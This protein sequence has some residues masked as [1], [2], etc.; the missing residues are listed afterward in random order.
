MNL[1]IKNVNIIKDPLSIWYIL[2]GNKINPIFAKPVEQVSK[3]PGIASKNLFISGFF[4][5]SSSFPSSFLSSSSSS[6]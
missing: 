1:D 6:S 2:A 5:S 3:K 4:S